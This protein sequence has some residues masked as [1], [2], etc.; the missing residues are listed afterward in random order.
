MTTYPCNILSLPFLCRTPVCP[1]SQLTLCP[2]VFFVTYYDYDGSSLPS[3]CPRTIEAS[4]QRSAKPH[5]AERPEP[6]LKEVDSAAKA[7]PNEASASAQTT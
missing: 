2:F 3:G 4:L 6:A 7:A 1:S 5:R